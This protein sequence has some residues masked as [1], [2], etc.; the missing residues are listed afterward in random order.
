MHAGALRGRRR[1]WKNALLRK[2]PW[3]QQALELPARLTGGGAHLE[4]KSERTRK[5]KAA[6]RR[7]EERSTGSV[8]R[9]SSVMFGGVDGWE[10]RP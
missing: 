6:A 1:R 9:A 8:K 7:G 3:R 4:R 10:K 5:E 2:S